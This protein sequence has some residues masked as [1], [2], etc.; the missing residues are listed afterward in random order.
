MNTFFVDA[1]TDGLYGR[2]LSV[3][4]V[5]TDESNRELDR[6]YA[7]VNV[8]ADE[9]ET[10]W[11]VENVYPHLKNA[12]TFFDSEYE[13]LE[14]FWTFWMKHREN[15]RCVSYVQYP[16]E[17][18]LFSTCVM[19][20]MA[21]RTFSA[22]FPLYDLST[23]LFERGLDFDANMQKLSGLDVSSHDAMNDVIMMA[24]VWNDLINTI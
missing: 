1:E 8:D 22:P 2:F 11:V 18:R 16:V 9:L 5:V 10:E 17:C 12:D 3:A 21:E 23:L 7:S 20:K 24:K 13:M 19:H 14:T 4:A 6:F 15:S